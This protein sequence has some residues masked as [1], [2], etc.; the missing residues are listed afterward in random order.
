VWS[1]Y[2]DRVTDA[3]AVDRKFEGLEPS[4]EARIDSG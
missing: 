1:E 2:F 3:I 4:K